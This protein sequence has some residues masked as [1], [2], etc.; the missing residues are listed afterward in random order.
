MPIHKK[1]DDL[2]AELQAHIA[3]EKARLMAEEGK[4]PEEAERIAR[5]SFGNVLRT[6]EDVRE[7]WGFA[8]GME[9][10]VQDCRFGWRLL[11]RTPGWTVT[12]LLTLAL[13]TGLSTAIFSVLHSTLFAPL[14]YGDADR[15]V[16]L[17]PVGSGQR[18]NGNAALWKHWKEHLTTV[19]D[20]AL[21]RPVANFNLTGEGLQPERLQGARITANL[22][23]VF[24][25][26]PLLGRG[27]T[28]EEQLAGAPVVLLSHR[29]W[30]RR[31]GGD[32]GVVGRKI[33]LNGEA[34]EVV[35]VMPASFAYPNVKFEVWAPFFL[36]SH[37]FGHGYSYGNLITGR[38]RPGTTLEA[39]QSELQTLMQGLASEFPAAYVINRTTGEAVSAR[40]EKLAD[41]QAS[42]VRPVLW[43]L[44]AATGCLLTLGC[45]NLAVLLIAKAAARSREIAV[46]AALGA[47]SSRL[48]RQLLAE[49]VPLGLLGSAGGVLC[50]W[51]ILRMLIPMLPSDMPRVETIG[52]H[53][54]VLVFAI[55]CSLAVVLLASLLPAAGWA[56][57]TVDSGANQLRVRGDAASA[58]GRLRELLAAG[59]VAIAVLLLFG[60]LLFGRSFAALLDVQPGFSTQDV[61]TMHL[62]VSR[63]KYPQDE[64]VAAYYQR[65]EARLLALPG[66]RGAGFVNR[67]PLSG[68]A[69]TGGVEFEG[70]EGNF[71][72]DWRSAS[73]GYFAAMGIPLVSGRVFGDT[74]TATSG[75]VGVI[76]AELARRVFGDVNP[77]GKRFRRSGI[78]GQPNTAPWCEIVGVAGHLRNDS[79]E[80]D[81]RPQ[82]YWPETQRTQDR[83]ALA[84][85]ADPSVAPS[86]L[87][88]LVISEIRK[89]N[90]D[91][92]VYDVRT[93]EEWMS[94]S[95]R[96]RTLTTSLLTLF[97]IASVSLACLG[98]YGVVSY[99]A[100]LRM[101]EFGI[102]VAMGATAGEVGR[103]VLSRAGRMTGIGALIGGLLCLPAGRAVQDFL[104][105][106][107][108]MDLVSWIAAPGALLLVGLLA[109]LGPALRAAKAD[110]AQTLRA[111]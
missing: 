19:P 38:I 5:A 96:G 68:V 71:G 82:V 18:F 9:R 13:G 97:G 53:W 105:G 48:R 99:G 17:S 11:L 107:R 110:P 59:Q 37:E 49:A 87:T 15:I 55:A 20:V 54:P 50:S 57:S 70:K 69:Q 108:A 2:N 61:L 78:P 104:F 51:L 28:E 30:M 56:S 93:M 101:R 65:L 62:A 102:R 90:P 81:N 3:I 26:P 72:T 92:P 47:S 41:F 36:P 27:F 21:T 63:A 89:E 88:S 74:D 52:L 46:R 8:A 106:V 4:E 23:R 14:P 25:V 7:T 73:P 60:G 91:Q 24:G 43:M 84:V 40:V 103:S 1:D 33:Q 100:S 79:L 22:T 10:F 6:R 95:M 34:H 64:Q 12:V 32:P 98:L 80:T 58:G 77:V 45:M 83:A 44:A 29:L 31:F 85:R 42:S 75:L 66:V 94:V 86:T 67:L 76:D 16:A 111:E 109:G 35:G 39:V